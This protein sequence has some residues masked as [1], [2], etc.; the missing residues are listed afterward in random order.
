MYKIESFFDITFFAKKALW[1]YQ[2]VKKYGF[3]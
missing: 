3:A 1:H 2:I